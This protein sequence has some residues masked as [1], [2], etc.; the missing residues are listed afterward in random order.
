MR[1]AF[2]RLFVCLCVRV[3]FKYY[4]HYFLQYTHRQC[5]IAK[6]TVLSDITGGMCVL[7]HSSDVCTMEN[8]LE[9]RE[10]EDKEK[11]ERAYK[12]ANI[13]VLCCESGSFT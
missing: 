10:I 6:R 4:T 13:A 5:S 1:V 11:W 8:D 12:F 2:V 9:N 3:Y 7:L